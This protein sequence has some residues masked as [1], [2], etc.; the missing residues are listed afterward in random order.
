MPP[1][2]ILASIV[3][4]TY[5]RCADIVTALQ[6]LD[7]QTLPPERFEV[8]VVVDGSSD[9]TLEAVRAH[10]PRYSLK[11]LWQ[12][13]SGRAAARNAG[14]ALA[15]GSIVI[16]LDDD[17][18]PEPDWLHAHV[19]AHAGRAG[20]GVL[21]PVPVIMDSASPLTVDY[22]GP[23]FAEHL[24]RLAA[25]SETIQPWDAYSGNFSVERAALEKVGRFDEA[26]QDYG[27][28]DVDLFHRLQCAGITLTYAP[29]AAARQRY[30]KG[31]PA[32]AADTRAKGKTA[33]LFAIK[34][35]DVAAD[36]RLG[37]FE[38]HSLQWRL[39][40]ALLVRLGRAWPGLM[41][42]LLGFMARL[43]RRRPTFL[44]VYYGFV[45][46]CFFWLGAF[47]ALDVYRKAGRPLPD[48][49]RRLGR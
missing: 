24:T 45:L 8:I 3:I 33:V 12:A 10:R 42:G 28:E 17:M 15:G 25:M 36:S 35:P 20:Y 22:I 46:D 21:G 40:R 13:N 23:K 38:N 2:P 6:A 16:L 31:F 9:G 43:E 1:T 34:H 41:E 26:F 47:D 32:L 18:L 44:G 29:A 11:A 14:I 4:P 19:E 5:Q 48:L 49:L 30:S 37:R 7:R 39:T 27:N